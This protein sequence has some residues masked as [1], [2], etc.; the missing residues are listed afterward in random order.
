VVRSVRVEVEVRWQIRRM[1]GLL[2]LGAEGS[3]ALNDVS[4]GVDLS[5]VSFTR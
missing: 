2:G 1:R 5:G 4:L 3:R